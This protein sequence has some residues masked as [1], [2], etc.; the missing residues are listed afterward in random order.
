MCSKTIEPTLPQA[1]DA[2]LAEPM[3]RAVRVRARCAFSSFS[4]W[5]FQERRHAR[6][7]QSTH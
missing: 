6:L 5:A 1:P 3:P 4:F 2:I 7:L